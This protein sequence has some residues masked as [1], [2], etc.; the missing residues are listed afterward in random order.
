VIFI[1]GGA[2][3]QATAQTVAACLAEAR[4][5][6][7]GAPRSTRS[8]EGRQAVGLG[9]GLFAKRRRRTRARWLALI[10]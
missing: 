6:K 10:I 5:A 2:H 4:S 9:S 1:T 3:S 7:A 8:R